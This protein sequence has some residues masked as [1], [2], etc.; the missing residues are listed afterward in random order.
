MFDELDFPAP[1][2][3]LQSLLASDCGLNIGML[4]K[5]HQSMNLVFLGKALH[6]VFSMFIAPP[7]EVVC[8]A[9]IERA[10][11]FGREDVNPIA[12]VPSHTVGSGVTGS[13]A[14]ADDDTGREASH[15]ANAYGRN[16]RT[17]VQ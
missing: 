15:R 17:A 5:V 10:A 8:H 2:P 7:N 12:A 1:I 14:F 11:D 13:S 6:Q 4:F 16:K 9:N 3:F